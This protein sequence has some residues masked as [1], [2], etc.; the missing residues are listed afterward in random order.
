M[1]K[2]KLILWT[3]FIAI[4]CGVYEI[5]ADLYQRGSPP[6]IKNY[7][8]EIDSRINLSLYILLFNL[9][10]MTELLKNN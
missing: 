4:F 7:I 9:R 5:S 10:E 6:I 1:N 8:I 3:I 2:F